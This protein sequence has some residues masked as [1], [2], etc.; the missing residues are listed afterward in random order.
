MILKEINS[1]QMAAIREQMLKFAHLQLRDSQLAEDMVQEALLNALKNLDSFKRNA[2]FKTWVFAIL[3]NKIIDYLRQKDRLVLESDL[4]DDE[5]DSNVFFDQD[6]H[7]R[8]ECYPQ[9]WQQP[10]NAVYS[11]EFWIIFELCL[12]KLPAKQA[13]MFM[14]REYLELSANEICHTAEISQ[15]NLHTLLYRSRLQLQQCLSSK[16]ILGG[17]K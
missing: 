10:E 16:S 17:K 3:K 9:E 12:T 5:N 1:S 15:A 8:E 2:A 11:D 13:H 4:R 14:M 7:W 6:G